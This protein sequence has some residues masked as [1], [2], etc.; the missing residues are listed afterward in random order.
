[1]Q[2]II[3]V[4]CARGK[5]LRESIVRD[6]VIADF[7]LVVQSKSKHGRN[8]GWAKVRS[9]AVDRRGTLNIVWHA[10]TNILSC[11]VVNRGAGR[12]NLILGDFVCY[13]FQRHH[14]RIRAVNIIPG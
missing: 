14:R 7:D 12:P 8:L 3:Q 13:L 1:M 5:S 6:G 9:K 10:D 2:T 11:R 4:V